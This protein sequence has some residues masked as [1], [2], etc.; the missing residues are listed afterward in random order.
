MSTV[1][2]WAERLSFVLLLGP[3][4]T[5]M[6]FLVFLAIDHV[7]SEREQIF[8]ECGGQYC[9]LTEYDNAR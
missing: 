7:M 1:N 8:Q 5:V 6:W 3:V 2:S 4:I 9:P